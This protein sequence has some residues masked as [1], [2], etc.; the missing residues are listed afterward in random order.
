MHFKMAGLVQGTHN[1]VERACG[2]GLSRCDEEMPDILR[3]L[4]LYITEFI[5]RSRFLT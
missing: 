3:Q 2:R 4:G 1:I 5:L